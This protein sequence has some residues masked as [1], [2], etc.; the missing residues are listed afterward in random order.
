MGL[1]SSERAT[2]QSALA[3]QLA[4][5]RALLDVS[6]STRRLSAEFSRLQA[7]GRNI[8]GNGVFVRY[9]DD[10]VRQ[11]RWMEV[12][13]AA[14]TRLATAA[15][16][17]EDPDMQ[18]ALLRLAGPR[19]EATLLGSLLLSV[20]LDLLHLADAVCTQHFYSVERMFAD[21]GR[22]QQQLEPAM[23]ALSSLEPGQV[24]AA[25]R[26]VPVLMGHLS[27]E[28]TATLET[29]RK[30]AERVAKVLVFKETIE[31]L[32]LLS[33]LKFSLPSVPLSAPALIGV[34]LVVG[35]DGVMV[36]T[37]LVVSAEWVE[38]M[39]HLVRAGVLSVPVVSAAVRIQAG[40]VMLAQTHGELPRGVREALGDG[41][42]VR[43]MRVTGR[44]GAGMNE[45]PRHHVLPKEFRA[46]F[47]KRG[48]T[49]EMDIDQFC[50]EM[51]Q[52]HHEAIHGGGNWK[53]GRQWPGEWNRMIM[54]ALW[55]AELRLN[56]LLTR[57]E[58]LDIVA[59]RMK[60]Y[61]LPMNFTRWGGR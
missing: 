20:W 8:G 48:F 24:E 37:R 56:R 18:L 13:L 46:W 51:Q 49:G 17:V 3:A 35:G 60:V 59:E 41:P 16:Q 10:G 44:A 4:F 42:E 61:K 9:V 40:Q 11:L 12:Q 30:G 58:V 5:R 31:A 21:L 29:S 43:G 19:L 50:V 23:T 28:F 54:K 39:R 38:M 57:N 53:L 14:A 45:P 1:N 32:S 27:G 15:S 25:A 52:A 22:W 36:G 47:E 6:G 2:R 7:R 34:S 55:D 26:D 33:A